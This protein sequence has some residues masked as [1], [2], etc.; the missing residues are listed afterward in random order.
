MSRSYVKTI[1]AIVIFAALFFTLTHWDQWHKKKASSSTPSSLLM[2]PLKTS[3]VTS[4]TLTPR[5]GKPVT[6]QRQ[7]KDWAIVAPR[8][9]PAAQDKINSFLGSLTTA[10]VSE[11]VDPH[12]ATVKDFGLDPAAETIDVT[13]SGKPQKLT[14][15]LGDMTPTGEGM[16]AQV[17]GNP[18]VVELPQ[19]AHSALV[20]TL[21]DLRDTRVV[22]LPADQLQK[23]QVEA[24][25]D[26][27]TL[28]KNPEGVWELSLPPAVRA[29]SYSVETMV[30]NLRTA[31][32]N[33]ILA[34]DKKD[35]AKY[36]FAKP[37][38]RLTATAPDGTQTI[39]LGKKDGENYDAM[40]SAL[41]PVFTVTQDFFN[42]FQKSADDLRDKNLWS[43]QTYD[44]KHVD[45]ET[46]KDHYVFD[47]QNGTWK[48]TSPKARTVNLGPMQ[49]FLSD[50]YDLQAESFPKAKP[51]DWKE[52]GLDKPTYTIKVT[53]GDKNKTEAVELA[54]AKGNLYGRRSED[55]L[56]SQISQTTL[57][58]VTKSLASL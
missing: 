3:E 32:M 47:K 21:F 31:T 10:T 14:L 48:E 24:G 17:A 43:W 20:Q 28:T 12:P 40:N 51:G 22:T 44:V 15:L 46:P 5:D 41:D 38:L 56:P 29:S 54:Q 26:N 13:S 7:G 36:A 30:D 25:A 18:R 57:D 52:F 35:D 37:A 2:A 6:C 50:L 49:T 45:L 16:Y 27:Y 55:V 11:V 4:F 19:Y 33:S 8:N 34:D 1:A 9:I 42:Q 58:T 39:V 53:F 23:I